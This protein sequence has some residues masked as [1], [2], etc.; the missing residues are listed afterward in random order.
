MSRAC[1]CLLALSACGFPQPDGPV[2]LPAAGVGQVATQGTT[3]APVYV[4]V[5]TADGMPLPGVPVTFA[6]TS[7]NGAVSADTVTTDA[8]GLA[9]ITW[10]LGAALGNQTLEARA[11]GYTGSPVQFIATATPM[12]SS[13]VMIAGPTG[14]F[15]IGDLDGDGRPDLAAWLQN[16][17]ASQ[18]DLF[19]NRLPSFTLAGSV[20]VLE[21]GASLAIAD[22]DSDHQPDLV[23]DENVSGTPHLSYARNLTAPGTSS[24]SFATSVQISNDAASFVVA[25][26]NKDGLPDLAT[27]TGLSAYLNTTPAG[28]SAVT[29]QRHSFDPGVTLFGPSGLSIGDLDGDHVPDA[30]IT[31]Q[32]GESQVNPL[33]AFQ[34]RTPQGA[35]DA[36]FDPF[37]FTGGP[38]ADTATVLDVDQ[39]GLGDVVLGSEAVGGMA[40]Q[41]AWMRSKSSAVVALAPRVPF[42]TTQGQITLMTSAD[43]DGDGVGDLLLADTSAGPTVL[44]N[45]TRAGSPTP[46]FSDPIELDPT[47][48]FRVAA[49]DLDG[50]GRQDVVYCGPTRLAVAFNELRPV[51]VCSGD[52]T[53]ARSGDVC[54]AGQCIAGPQETGGLGAACTANRDCASHDCASDGTRAACTVIC[55]PHASLCPTGFQCV[56]ANGAGA[57]VCWAG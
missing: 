36:S 24:L 3:L 48:A 50:D 8:R 30:V 6:V 39:D 1:A 53:C 52:T 14:G 10:R 12:F 57:G 34:N 4:A 51:A 26:L 49:A 22:L 28:S 19:L 25:D 13:P 7:G 16:G 56:P 27:E 5:E 9:Q 32:N 47:S 44:L 33:V 38:I 35:T 41:L 29:F 20:P 42:V 45:L 37:H 43:L 55:A 40:E 21:G 2:I 23:F 15:A 17:S 18:L 11:L 31:Y 46:L 54:Y